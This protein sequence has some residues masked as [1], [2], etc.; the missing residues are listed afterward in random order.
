MDGLSVAAS[1]VG[2]A[3]AGVQVSIK[4]VTLATQIRTASDRVSSIG[5]D[6][7]LTSSVLHQLGELM[8]QNATADGISILN[9]HG[10][11]TTKTSAAMCERIFREIEKEVTRASEQLRNCKPSRGRMSG[12]KIELSMKEKAKWPFLQPKIDNLRTDLRDAKS[13]LMLMLQLAGLALSKKAADAS[14]STSENQDF[15]R[16]IVAWELQRREER[17]HPEETPEV[18]NNFSPDNTPNAENTKTRSLEK[19]TLSSDRNPPTCLTHS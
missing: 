3:T 12:E 11:Q 4:L 6:I 19:G 7:S 13:T 8:R 1:I 9:Q 2:I 5:N 17:A 18:T 15:V 16:A 14:M 10:I